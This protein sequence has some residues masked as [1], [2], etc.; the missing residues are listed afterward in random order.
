MT[1]ALYQLSYLFSVCSS[2]LILKLIP[3]VVIS[4]SVIFFFFFEMLLIVVTVRQRIIKLDIFV[5][6]LF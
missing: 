4:D 5:L 6:Y 1:L 3:Y 2:A